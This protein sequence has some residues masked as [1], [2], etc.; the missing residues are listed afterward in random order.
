MLIIHEPDLGVKD[1]FK[2]FCS[3]HSSYWM[4]LASYFT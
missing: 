3:S 2:F 1:L 4:L